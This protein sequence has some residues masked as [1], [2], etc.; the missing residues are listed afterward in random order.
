MLRDE[1]KDI[2]RFLQ[3]EKALNHLSPSTPKRHET[4]AAMRAM[5]WLLL[6]T[7][8]LV[9]GVLEV[10]A[11]HLHGPKATSDGM[12]LAF[13]NLVEQPPKTSVSGYAETSAVMQNPC[14]LQH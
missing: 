9:V 5:A 13:E 1:G 3:D 14:D 11:A 8:F 12:Q 7:A 4:A 10:G 6:T 2:G